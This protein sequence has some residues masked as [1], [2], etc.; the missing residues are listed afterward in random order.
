MG[1]NE[2]YLFGE[3][4]DRITDIKDNLGIA[5]LLWWDSR[6]CECLIEIFTPS[7]LYDEKDFIIMNMKARRQYEADNVLL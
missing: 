2:F 6:K 5:G 4:I 1:M 7:R 3:I